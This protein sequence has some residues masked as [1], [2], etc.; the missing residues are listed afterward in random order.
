VSRDER[1][2]AASPV[3]ASGRRW[4][5]DHPLQDPEQPFRNLKVVLV[6]G[7]VERDQNGVR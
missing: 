5:T 4:S 7:V 1:I 3:G 2:Y 6:T